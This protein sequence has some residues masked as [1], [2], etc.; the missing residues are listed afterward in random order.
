MN[1]FDFYINLKKPSLGLYV[2]K[3]AGLSDLADAGDWQ[4]DGTMTQDDLT[5]TLLKE[6][7]ANGHAF[8]ELEGE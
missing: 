8:Q 3:G 5:P 2:R 1:E 4:L 6:L 7:Q